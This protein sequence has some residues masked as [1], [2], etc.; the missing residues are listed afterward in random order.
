MNRTEWLDLRQK[1]IG[2]SE[3][4][5]ILGKS[6]YMTNQDLYKIKTDQ[7]LPDDISGL[8]YVEYGTNAEE[9]LRGLFILDFPEY[10]VTYKDFD[11]VYHPEHDFIFATLDGR[12]VD[13]DGRKGVLE[14]KTCEIMNGE[15][16]RKWK[17]QIP[18]QYYCQLC[19]QLLATGWDFAIL[20]AQLKS[21]WNDELFIECRHYFI[22][23]TEIQDQLD[24]LLQEEI[25]FW[26]KVQAKEEPGLLLPEI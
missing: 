16:R 23:R 11:I 9:Y 26:N 8:S 14:I 1:G 10:T 15:M 24:F 21:R 19:H 4:A 2:G 18:D 13:K 25:K 20:K 3:A 6:P 5:A 7:K 12:L 22:D 17:G